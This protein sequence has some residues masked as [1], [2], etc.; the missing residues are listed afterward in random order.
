MVDVG[1]LLALLQNTYCLSIFNPLKIMTM[2]CIAQ[3]TKEEKDVEMKLKENCRQLEVQIHPLW[4]M[5]LYHKAD[6]PFPVTR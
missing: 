2:V 4:G 3:V 5:S 6:L 1:C